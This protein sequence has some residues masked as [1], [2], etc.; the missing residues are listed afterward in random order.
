MNW[1]F[2]RCGLGVVGIGG[3]MGV[4]W[5]CGGSDLRPETQ[6]ARVAGRSSLVSRITSC[7][8]RIWLSANRKIFNRGF[9]AGNSWE[10]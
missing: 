1:F 7:V 9:W 6:G 3:S 4:N 5:Q 10:F 8:Y 2:E